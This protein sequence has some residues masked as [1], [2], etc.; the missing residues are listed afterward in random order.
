MNLHRTLARL[1]DELLDKTIVLSYTN[2][3]YALRRPFW[4]KAEAAMQ[5]KVCVVT[6]ANSGLGKATTHR[7]AALG[8]TVYMLCRNQ[9]HGEA[10]RAEIVERSDNTQVFLEIVDLSSQT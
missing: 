5:D 1:A 10:A 8:A 9:E 4:K 2:I 6:G 3:G 7:L